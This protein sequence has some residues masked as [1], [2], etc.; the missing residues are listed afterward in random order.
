[1]S[2]EL[3]SL[4]SVT[5]AIDPSHAIMF[6]SCDKGVK[7]LEIKERAL[8][9]TL[10]S[11]SEIEKIATKEDK[12]ENI[13][14]V[15]NIQTVDGCF[16]PLEHNFLH[17]SGTVKFSNMIDSIN[18]NETQPI[19]D[20]QAYY[21]SKEAQSAIDEIAKRTVVQFLKG[22][23]LHRNARSRNI[24]LS[25][26]LNN[27]ESDYS[28]QVN[29]RT[30]FDAD[31]GGFNE[32]ALQIA[33]ALKGGIEDIL[34]ISYQYKIEV[35]NGQEVYPSEEFSDGSKKTLFRVQG[36]QAGMHSQKI[37]NGLRTIDDW[38]SD[39]CVPAIP[40]DPFGPHKKLGKLERSKNNVFSHIDK[41][42]NHQ[43][44]TSNEHCYLTASLIRGGVYSG[45]SKKPPKKPSKK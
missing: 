34:L 44:M 15:S 10:G 2:K 32:V 29:H 39:E 31:L 6:S 37:G 21:E 16:L 19:K 11:Y 25:I 12:G 42:I 33:K 4:L 30:E 8:T 35:G 14:L 9:G 41:L 7:P 23:P 22:A 24:E 3:P 20:I 43:P 36:Q 1:M 45:P 38:Y 27:D 40:V 13:D 17:V 18:C 28:T 5:G 26:T